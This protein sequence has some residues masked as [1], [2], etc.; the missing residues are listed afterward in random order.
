MC[1]QFFNCLLRCAMN[2]MEC[3]TCD[4]KC[5]KKYRENGA[6]NA[7]SGKLSKTAVLVI[8]LMQTLAL[9]R[10]AEPQEAL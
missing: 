4:V 5:D 3:F 9:H 10:T 2:C 6:I 1:E 7:P 8:L